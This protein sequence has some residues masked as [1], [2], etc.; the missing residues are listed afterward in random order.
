[1]FK[2]K[3][4]MTSMGSAALFA[5]LVL[6][7]LQ[8]VAADAPEPGAAVPRTASLD[9]LLAEQRSR[10]DQRAE[11]LRKFSEARRF[12]VNPWAEMDRKAWQAHND[13]LRRGFEYR[14]AWDQAAF[15]N[16]REWTDP[17]ADAHMAWMDRQTEWDRQFFDNQRD[18][19]ERVMEAEA[20][21]VLA[22]EP[23]VPVFVPY[24]P[25]W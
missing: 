11:R 19:L 17:W 18:Y 7:A 16:L 8:A 13:A 15:D 2:R 9:E 10:A 3:T 22:H 12:L 5:G 24:A 21:W 23:P 20:A 6:P 25:W 4:W 1:M 14:R